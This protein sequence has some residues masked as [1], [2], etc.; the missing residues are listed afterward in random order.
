MSLA[1]ISVHLSKSNLNRGLKVFGIAMCM[2]LVTHLTEAIFEFRG[3]GIK[4]GILHFL[5]IAMMIFQLVYEQCRMR[6]RGL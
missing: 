3:M 4:F 5:G 1:G 6:S 2:T